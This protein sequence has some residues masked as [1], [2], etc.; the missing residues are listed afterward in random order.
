MSDTE[1]NPE[2]EKLIDYIKSQR[3][4]DFSGYKR[5]TL[6]RRINK[7]LQFLGMENYGKYLNYLKLEPQELVELFDTVLI[8]VTGFFRDSSTW[9][10]IQNQIVPHIVARKQ[11]QEPI[12][13]WSAGCASGQEAY[14]LAIVFAE[15]LGVEQFCDRVKIYATDVD[16][17]ALNQARLATYNAKEFDGLPAEILEKYFYKID[18][19]YRFRP[20]LR[21]SLIF[22]RHDL[23]QDPPIS[24]LDLLTC[25]NTLMYFN[26][27]T[28][29]KIIARLHY[30]LNTGGFL[31]MG[32]AEMLLCRSSSFATVDL[33]RRIFIKTQ[34][35]TRRE[36][37][38]SMTQ[39]DKNE[40]TNYLVSNSRLRDA[41]FEASPVVQ[42]VINIKGQLA[43]ANEAARQMFA[44]GTKDIGRPLQDLELSYRPVEL[45]SL[46]DQ[47]YA[48]HRSTT[49]GGVAW[50]NSTGEIA[51]FDVQ[52]NPLVN[53]SGKILGVS[54]V[55]T[56]ITSSKKLQ[57]DVEKANQEL[58]MA[59]EELQCT[60]EELETTNEELQSSNEEL[61]TTNEEL[62]ST[63]EEL[64]TMNEE[65]Q[66]SNEELQTMNEE[67]RLRSDDLNQ[68][69]AFLESVLSC[70]HSGVIVINRDLQIE[71]WNHQAEN[72]WGLRHEEV[73]GQHLMNL[74]IGLPVEQ[75]R[76]PLRSC[77]TGEEKNIVVNVVAID[78][79]GRT[80][81][82]NISC[83]PLYSATKEIRGAILF[84]EV[85]SNA[86]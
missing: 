17:A 39:N 80:I 18:N 67:L 62:Q 21:R 41:A 84:M 37:L 54:V 33:K 7:R 6:L 29:A 3:G 55:F 27:E 59:Y 26:S 65:L 72:L 11:P 68:A 64:E 74:N 81:Q 16:M 71:I 40:Q 57:D 46:I 61:E 38:Y 85:N 30:A 53:F 76:Q 47:V 49:I 45:R 63:N 58:E 43:L 25:R 48:S 73:Q 24:H 15:V 77:L 69:N 42:L 75:L 19:F 66:S 14:T 9:E 79:R 51:Y 23:I 1:Q 22:G 34:Q 20:N 70:L 35:N 5:S 13:I 86:S 50:T 82:C 83:N 60:N 2:F 32:K 44:L 31:C 36:H 52:I 4:F 56:N 28:Q 8:N 12:R 78:R 10:Y